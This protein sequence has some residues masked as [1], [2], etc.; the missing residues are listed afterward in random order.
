MEA[1]D[2][3]KPHPTAGMARKRAPSQDGSDSKRSKDSGLVGHYLQDANAIDK[4]LRECLELNIGLLKSKDIKPEEVIQLLYSSMC[5]CIA[6]AL[7]EQLDSIKYRVVAQCKR[8]RGPFKS[9][10]EKQVV[11]IEFSRSAFV[12]MEKLGIVD[13]WL[14]T[15]LLRFFVSLSRPDS[16][17][18]KVAD[19]WLRQ[20]TDVLRDFCSE[21]LV[22]NL[23]VRYHDQLRKGDIDQGHQRMLCV[24][25]EHEF[26][27]FTLA[28][29][30]KE[31]AFLEEILQI[32]PDVITYLQTAPSNSVAV[33][34]LFDMSYAA[35]IFFDVYQLFWPLLE[36]HVLSLKLKGVMSISLRG[37][38]V[39][40][41]IKN[42][43]QTGQNL[44]QQTEVCSTHAWAVYVR[45]Y[46]CIHISHCLWEYTV[47]LY[48][49][50]H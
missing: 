40:Y 4:E 23:P 2:S 26:T 14:N 46:I 7:D 31:I 22:K 11:A 18:R 1:E 15:N 17:Q 38:H 8:K 35:L 19:Y 3:A 42:A 48:F 50:M 47:G 9:V 29:L 37:P 36:H 24:V 10:S 28:D 34:W 33:Y 30:L 43:L 27:T 20:Y 32:P 21:F 16:A 6:D 41:L 25:C 39:S 5:Q 49:Y 13:R 45:T 44:I 12:I